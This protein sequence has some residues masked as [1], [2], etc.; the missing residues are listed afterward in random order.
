MAKG[1][2]KF[3]AP[4]GVALA[5]LMATVAIAPGARAEDAQSYIAQAKALLAKGDLKGAEIE[6]RN[7]V[8]ESPNDA[9][10]HVQLAQIY[11]KL[12]NLPAAEAEARLARQ[13][14]AS[15]SDV[16][17]LLAQALVGEGKPSQLFDLVKLDDR[18][19][20]MELQVRLQLGLAHLALGEMKEAEPLLRD[21][22]RLDGTSV[23]AKVG[24][25]QFEVKKGDVD[26]AEAELSRAR[27]IA[28]EDLSALRMTAEI[29]FGKGDRAGA[30][31]EF[32]DILA[33][34]P[35]DL[36]TL[37]D[38]ANAL[39]SQGKLDEAQ[40]D[41]DRALKLSPK[42]VV[43]NF[44]D[45]LL[46]S[47]KGDLKAAD[48]RLTAISEYF[49]AF[50]DG[51]YLEGA[52]QYALGEY[53]QA[54]AN[55][56]KYSVRNPTFAPARRLLAL[57]AARSHD[58]PRVIETLTPVVAANSTDTAA[59]ALLAQAYMATGKRD[60]AVALFQNAAAATADQKVQTQLALMQMQI[61][62]TVEGHQ[63]RKSCGQRQRR[64]CRRSR[65]G[66]HRSALR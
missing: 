27:A 32:G 12:R 47:K 36:D 65:A 10:V 20:K 24:L 31:T 58:W 38:R 30:L 42:N 52:V 46:L 28:P 13:F 17:P 1:W 26:Y 62:E 21:A 64:R 37:F 7:A 57:I 45:A 61:G 11:L 8:R 6:L 4:G 16:D 59:V 14:K 23:G 25:A 56:N 39:M 51:Y 29:H 55:L 43:G 53:A 35:N 33:K 3:A 2:R 18:D 63:T 5:A 50:P 66:H 15:P 22:E 40:H 9:S 49:S 41:I 34:H 44:L 54:E 19:P 60:Q 48:E